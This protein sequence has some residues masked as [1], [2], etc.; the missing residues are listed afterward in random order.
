MEDHRRSGWYLIGGFPLGAG[1]TLMVTWIVAVAT[2]SEVDKPPLLGWPSYLAAGLIV[3][4]F[5]LI[6]AV[7]NDWWPFG[8]RKRRQAVPDAPSQPINMDKFNELR[9]ATRPAPLSDPVT[10]SEN[11]IYR[12]NEEV[13]KAHR[14]PQNAATASVMP[15]PKTSE[16]DRG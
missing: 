15:L 8:W 12:Y 3:G 11:R 2:H 1:A 6:L 4:G 5:V 7:M 13:L 9:E 14:L 16:Q 10:A